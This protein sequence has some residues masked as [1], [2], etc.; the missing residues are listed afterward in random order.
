MSKDKL[1]F[2]E[3]TKFSVNC[4][5]GCSNNCRYCYAKG[6]AVRFR[7]LTV[8]EWPLERIR[9]KDVVKQQKSYDGRVM[10]P[11]S[12]DIT[13]ANLD[14]CMTV[15]GN[16]LGAGNELLIVSKPRIECID[17]ICRRFCAARDRILFRF[18]IGAMDDGILAFWEPGA[19]TYAERRDSLCLA[20]EYGFGTSVSIEPMLDIGHVIDLVADLQGCVTDA[21][22]IGKMNHIKKSMRLV[23]EETKAAFEAIEA[24]QTAQRILDIYE[25]LKTNPKI[26][27]K[28]GIKKIVGIDIPEDYGLDQ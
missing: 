15:I 26:K 23:D 10:F 18:T 20:H 4:C 21:I 12:H 9:E 3:W 11:S 28:E 16:L 1:G 25:Q 24:R 6:M 5:S 8:E 2:R 27:W 7:Q 14:A 13:L 22:W 17:R 19:P